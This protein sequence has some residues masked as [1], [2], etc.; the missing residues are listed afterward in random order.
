M[1]ETIS[2]GGASV[3]GF[4]ECPVIQP[5]GIYYEG[6]RVI[7]LGMGDVGVGDVGD[8]LAYRQ[9]WEPFIAAHV[10]LWREVNTLLESVPAAQQCPPGVAAAASDPTG[11]CAAL[12]HSRIRISTTDPGGI[13]PQWNAWKDKSSADVVAGAASMLAFHQDVVMRVG[14]PYAKDLLEIGKIWGIPIHLPDVPSFSTQQEIRARIEGA[15]ITA[16]GVVQLIGYSAGELLGEA[17]D[18]VQATAQ[19]LTEAAKGIPKALNWALIAGAVAVAVVGGAL[20]VYYLPKRS[21]P[22]QRSLP[23]PA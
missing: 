13:L 11:F 9:E 20:V 3:V 22:V 15:Y 12:Q 16:K 10:A 18:L 6:R 8:L 14:G 4:G 19:G 21:A 1:N 17:H 2:L 7:R 23:E 5:D